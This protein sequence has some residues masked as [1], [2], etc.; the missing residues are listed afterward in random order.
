MES[1]DIIIQAGQS[2]SEGC[3][4]GAVEREF[5]PTDD[6]WYMNRDFGITRAKEFEGPDGKVNQFA[7]SFCQEYIKNGKLKKGRK[8][9]ILRA[10]VGGT[11]FIDNRWG[12][13]DD[14]YLT[15]LEM[16]KRALAPNPSNRLVALLWHQGECDASLKSSYEQYYKNISNLAGGVRDTFKVP[17]LPFAAGDFVQE[18][19]NGSAEITDACKPV[20]RALR[21][22]CGNTKNARFVQSDGLSSNNQDVGNGDTIHFSRKGLYLLGLRYYS[23]L[24]DLL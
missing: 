18:W 12:L 21:D 15:M 14:L 22:F 6:I 1:Y 24:E 16:I 17:A 11:G 9:L 23:A 2:N 20:I 7:L 4:L 10:A 5:V 3:G 13:K 19:K 8:L